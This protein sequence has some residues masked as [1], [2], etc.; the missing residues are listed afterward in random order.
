MLRIS[1]VP[2]R[3][4]ARYRIARFISPLLALF[5]FGA[6]LLLPAAGFAAED[7]PEVEQLK[8]QAQN[9]FVKGNY[10]EAEAFDLEIAEKHPES[11]ARR[12]AVQMLGTMYENNL[13][14]LKKAIRWDREFLEKY[15]EARQV[16][17]YQEQIASLE[18]LLRQE[19]AFK[20]YKAIQYAQYNDHT[21][22]TKYEAFLKRY[23]DFQLRDKVESELGFA[24]GR[25]DERKKSALAFQAMASQAEGKLPSLDRGAY[26]A[27]HRY[28]MLRTTGA[29]VAWI[30]IVVLWAWV[31]W[32]NP[33]K[34]LTWRSIRRFLLWPVLWLVV[35]GASMPL[36][37][38]METKGYSITIPAITV[39]IAI[40]LNL[41]VLFWLLLL[42]H[43]KTW[44]TRPQARRWLSP[45]LALL[46]TTG[47]FY[48][49][50]VYQPNGPYIVDVCV[51]KYSYWRGELR[52]WMAKRRAEGQSARER[53]KTAD[54]PANNSG[55]Q[56]G[57]NQG[58]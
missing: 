36:F 9:A 38:S 50:V 48:L 58:R 40:G 7:S 39:Y 55:S 25:L 19:Q 16:P 46:M 13:V 37:Y 33:W 24:Y 44:Q 42:L 18:K 23:P 4:L 26:E 30:V 51:V 3:K 47:V 14:D 21:L 8:Q 49:W 15:A 29:W 27:A 1:D 22:V 12:Y 32:M 11:Q 53:G 57:L 31:L 35:T 20:A 10:A 41:L 34:Q 5:M 43:G 56:Q 28:W 17:F 54:I 6:V 2:M 45:V 52:E